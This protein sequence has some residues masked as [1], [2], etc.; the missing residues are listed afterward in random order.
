MFVSRKEFKENIV[1]MLSIERESFA[2]P[3]NGNIFSSVYN[4]EMK[5]IH[6]FME[7]VNDEIAGYLILSI[8][9]DE[10]EIINIAVSPRFRKAGVG[11]KLTAEAS[12]YARSKGAVSIFLEVRESN[13]AARALYISSGFFI[14]GRRKKYYTFLEEDA[15]VMRKDMKIE[16]EVA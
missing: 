3:M 16:T 7:K 2:D 9:A 11:K 8:V 4:D 5:H 13:S 12:E 6:Y 1:A 10:A 15:I 14:A